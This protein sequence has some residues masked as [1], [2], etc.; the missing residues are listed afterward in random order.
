MA[1]CRRAFYWPVIF[2]VSLL[3]FVSVLP[4]P[5]LATSCASPDATMEEKLI[6]SSFVFSGVPQRGGAQD[7]PFT[8]THVYK[9]PSAGLPPSAQIIVS[10]SRPGGFSKAGEEWL[11][12][13]SQTE[14]NG[15]VVKVSTSTVCGESKRTIATRLAD[16]QKKMKTPG[17][18][19]EGHDPVIFTGRVKSS[20]Q[21]QTAPKANVSAIVEFELLT[22]FRNAPS[23]GQT[24]VPPILK[25][26][27]TIL[28][29]MDGGGSQYEVGHSYLVYAMRRSGGELPG[30][31]FQ[32]QNV[33]Y[34]NQPNY[35]GGG[36]DLDESG[37]LSK[38][39]DAYNHYQ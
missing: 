22:V 24:E 16:L 1:S 15:N 34:Y 31:A 3:L 19:S 23:P 33:N 13:G 27:D 7:V 17:Q 30:T 39:S 2:V 12:F 9:S 10:S 26:L 18:F 21:W 25:P 5:A 20:Y 32:F 29:D 14:V 6:H 8:I 37:I 38:L 35:G 11:I 4:T 36:G 28:V